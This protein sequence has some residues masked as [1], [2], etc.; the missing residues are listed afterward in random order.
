MR[1]IKKVQL[2]IEQNPLCPQSRVLSALIASL[3]SESPFEVKELYT[4]EEHF[5][6]IAILILSDWRLDR[7]CFGNARLFDPASN[8][9]CSG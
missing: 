6:E 1:T 5:F 8:V 7:Y 4:L 2:S 9:Q 3:K